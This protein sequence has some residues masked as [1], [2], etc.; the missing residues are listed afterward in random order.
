ME[1]AQTKP[2][3]TVFLKFDAFSPYQGGK[4]NVSFD[5]L[6]RFF[7]YHSHISLLPRRSH[8]AKPDV[9]AISQKVCLLDDLTIL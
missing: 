5:T 1:G 2:A 4:V 7:F 9:R 3:F 6:D 8:Q